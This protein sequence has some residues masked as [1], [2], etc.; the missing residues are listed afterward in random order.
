MLLNPSDGV[1]LNGN[2]LVGRSYLSED[3]GA[4]E[5]EWLRVTFLHLDAR[6]GGLGDFKRQQRHFY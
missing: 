2:R 4:S 5:L 6:L 1:N 3:L